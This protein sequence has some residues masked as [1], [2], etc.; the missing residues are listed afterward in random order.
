MNVLF[1]GCFINVCWLIGCFSYAAEERK[2]WPCCCYDKREHSVDSWRVQWLHIRRHGDIQVPRG[3]STTSGMKRYDMI[4]YDTIN[5]N[6]LLTVGG[7]SSYTLGDMV[8]YKFPGVIAPPQVWYDMIWY[9]MI[10]YDKW[11]HIVYSRRIQWL[12]IRGHGDI[13]VPRGHSTTSGM[14]R[15]DMIQYD[16]INGNILLT[17]GGYSGYTLGDMVTYKFPGVIAPPQVWYNVIWY[18][19]IR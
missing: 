1:A 3:H 8:T 19:M 14:I 2:I 18:N 7:Y 12:H 5:G 10:W 13:Q 17:V 11:K 4:W 15:Y 6:I 16:T 9:D